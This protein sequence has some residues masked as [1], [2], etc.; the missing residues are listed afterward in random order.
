MRNQGIDVAKGM[1][2]LLVLLGHNVVA[3]LNDRGLFYL[4]GSFHMPLFFAVSGILLS[5]K[6]GFKDQL[7]A[8]LKNILY[9]Y[10]T[11]TVAFEASRLFAKF[12]WEGVAGV[13]QWCDAA[14]RA[15]SGVDQRN[16]PMWFLPALFISMIAGYSVVRLTSMAGRAAPIVGGVFSVLFYV[17]W[18]VFLRPH[19]SGVRVDFSPW[20]WSFDLLPLTT[21]F[22][23]LGWSTRQI[24][25]GRI[26]L[27]FFIALAVFVCVYGFLRP[28]T[29]I[30][31][32]LASDAFSCFVCAASGSAMVVALGYIISGAGKAAEALAYLG[33]ASL[34]VMVFHYVPETQI[35]SFLTP[36]VG[37]YG[38]G[39]VSF[40]VALVVSLAGYE[41]ARRYQKIGRLFFNAKALGPN[42]RASVR[43]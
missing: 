18:Y 10:F 14:L 23:L 21:S 11:L 36:R 2:I 40:I 19:Q 30:N 16:S 7:I 13:D 38:A 24:W 29:D 6:R 22:V 37:V 42:P 8:C 15:M 25:G 28:L 39:W 3:N 33:R 27:I 35:G 41:V 9:P 5:E 20:P 1:G 17:C 32:R 4:V 12:I 43:R 26:E 34:F 31:A